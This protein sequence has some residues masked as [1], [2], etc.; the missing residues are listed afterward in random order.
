MVRIEASGVVFGKKNKGFTLTGAGGG[1]SG[2]VITDGTSGVRVTGNLASANSGVGFVFFFGFNDDSSGH[3]LRDNAAVAND[4]DGFNFAGSGHVLSGNLAIANR[5]SGFEVFGSGHVLTGNLA[6]ANG[7]DGFF[8]SGNR[9]MLSGNSALG[10]GRFGILVGTGASATISKNNIFGNNGVPAAPPNFSGETNCGLLNR[11]GTTIDAR[12]NFW[13]TAGG[14]G[15]DPAD[16]VCNEGASST[17]VDSFATKEFKVKTTA[18]LD[19]LG[20]VV[21]AD[22]E[23]NETPAPASLSTQFLKELQTKDG[24]LFHALGVVNALRLEVT[25]LSGGK[26]YDSGFVRGE[27]LNWQRVD[28]KHKPV[29]NGVYLYR[30]TARH[31]D[32]K[33][34]HS[35]LRK[36]IISK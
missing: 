8:F 13:G 17:T 31:R 29:A 20:L 28:T 11:T 7:A 6:S 22:S 27:S 2:L 10:N 21:P 36:L 26:I 19:E 30:L 18:F 23:Q 5:V 1:S 14:P 24:L 35:E 34:V 12:N 9:H 33:E 4:G 32:G 16:N 3:Q 25:D 15:A